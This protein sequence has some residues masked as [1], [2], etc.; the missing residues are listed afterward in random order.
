MEKTQFYSHGKLLL[1]AE[2]LVLDGAE[3]LALPT[4]KGQYLYIS[5]Q[6]EKVLSWK[7]FD[8]Q[9]N[10][11]FEAN[12][13]IKEIISKTLL[14]E[15]SE[16]KKTL[17]EILHY[18]HQLNPKIFD[19]P[20]GY[21]VETKLT[22]PRNWG[23]GTSST[24]INNIAQWFEID[25]FA[26]L[27]LSFGGSGYDIA[28]AQVNF[29]IVYKIEKTQPVYKA[30]NF[31]PPKHQLFFVYLNQKQNSK[32]A[33]QAYYNKRNKN[34][35][36]IITISHL[37]QKMITAQSY[38]ELATLFCQHEAMMSGILE[39]QTVKELYF[40][41]FNGEIKSLGAW[42]GDFV[43]ALSKTD[44]SLYFGNKGFE[45]VIPYCEMIL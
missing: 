27:R 26:L 5:S 18:A 41:D 3:A 25:A 28:C 29:P 32:S 37:T 44:P 30:V 38:E 40:S 2:Y 31:N 12:L 34:D 19:H 6:L 43:L 42:G 35:E 39:L 33:I 7:S 21:V 15:D 17:I 10:I 8:D 45:T 23:L 11:W 20:Q 14:E 9:G 24:L 36:A 22:F 13:N 4:Q 1:T 16:V